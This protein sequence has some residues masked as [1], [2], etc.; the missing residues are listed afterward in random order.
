MN[1]EKEQISST[2]TEILQPKKK[3]PIKLILIIIVHMIAVI[4]IGYSIFL[5][6]KNNIPIKSE[7]KP[8][9]LNTVYYGTYENKDALFILNTIDYENSE[10]K[11][12]YLGHLIQINYSELLY[13]TDIANFD[14]RKLDKPLKIFSSEMSSVGIDNFMFDYSKKNIFISSGLEIIQINL[15]NMMLKSIWKNSVWDGSAAYDENAI[16]E[17]YP[18][19]GGMVRIS[20]I[21][22]DNKYLVLIMNDVTTGLEPEQRGTIILNINTLK[23]V[24]LSDIG[25]VYFNEEK[26]SFSYQKLQP[27]TVLCYA[28]LGCLD[29]L[30]TEMRP[31]GKVYTEPLP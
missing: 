24:Y 18:N 13:P 31:A 21:S 5:N 19:G 4:G 12:P 23:E 1:D 14:F 3:L 2:T 16:K 25:G 10:L 20:Q 26:N 7:I 27:F 15:D 8:P 11:N 30:T 29:G 9:E 6:L 17:K 22:E 28:G